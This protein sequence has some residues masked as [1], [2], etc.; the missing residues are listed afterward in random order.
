MNPAD[1]SIFESLLGSDEP[2]IEWKLRREVL[3]QPEVELTDLRERIR[4]SE[5]VTR[6]LAGMSPGHVY[7]K[8]HGAHWVLSA[9]AD[10]GYPSG[11]KELAPLRDRVTAAWLDDQYYSEFEAKSS[12]SSYGKKGVPLI[13]GRYRRCGSIHGNALRAICELG[14]A[15]ERADQ[16]VERLLHWQ[17]PDGGW[18]CDRNPTADTS[19]FMETLLPMRG[20]QAYSETTRN[21]PA[22]EAARRAAEVFLS[23]GMFRRRL[24][25]TVINP[26]FVRLH[27]P[28]YWHYDILGGLRG[29]AEVG[30]LDDPR[31]AEALDLLEEMRLP[32]GGWSA[33]GRFYSVSTEAKPNTDSVDWG[34]G[35]S[36]PNPWVTADALGVLVAAGRLRP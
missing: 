7:N 13:D 23:R 32:G 35:R 20:L 21:K 10:L 29:M 8:W 22:G 6:L 24:D 5:R 26:D 25:G 15:D 18:N 14:L 19:S 36:K 3:G 12:S 31:C 27:Y 16:L 11:A 33:G 4:Q 28:L 17:W 1:S 34:S 30:L 9:L 2:S